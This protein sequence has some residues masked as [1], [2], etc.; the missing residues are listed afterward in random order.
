MNEKDEER[1]LNI[2][3]LVIHKNIQKGTVIQKDTTCDSKFMLETVREVGEKYRSL[4]NGSMRR[5]QYILLLI[6]QED[7][8]Q[9]I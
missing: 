7:M 6:T 5:K 3:D 9:W 4:I 8:G 1:S 2:N